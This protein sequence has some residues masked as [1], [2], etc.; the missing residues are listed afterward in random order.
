MHPGEL[1]TAFSGNI[2]E[3]IA[4]RLRGATET[5]GEKGGP[6]H[7]EPERYEGSLPGMS[8]QVHCNHSDYVVESS[9]RFAGDFTFF[10]APTTPAYGMLEPGTYC[11][12]GAPRTGGPAIT[13]G[14]VYDIT[15]TPIVTVRDF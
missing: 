6:D 13:D 15:H 5:S 8:V 2:Q 14:S 7:F 11:F 12:S 3:F 4:S 9:P 10:G 1:I